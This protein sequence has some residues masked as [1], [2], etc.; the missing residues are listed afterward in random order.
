MR[1]GTTESST[2]CA[3]AFPGPR[4]LGRNDLAP[5][6]TGPPPGGDGGIRRP[7]TAGCTAFSGLPRPHVSITPVP[8]RALYFWNRRASSPWLSSKHVGRPAGLVNG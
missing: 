1:P 3:P 8:N 4:T 5:V 7:A 6:R 2:F